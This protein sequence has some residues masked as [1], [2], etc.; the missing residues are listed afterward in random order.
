MA[1]MSYEGLRQ[2]GRRW[3]ELRRMQCDLGV[4]SGADGSC[5]FTCGRTKIIASCFVV[6]LSKQKASAARVPTTATAAAASTAP[7]VELRV[8]WLPFATQERRERGRTDRQV[9]DLEGMLKQTACAMLDAS[10][11]VVQKQTASGRGSSGAARGNNMEVQIKVAVLQADGGVRSCCVNAVTC[12]IGMANLVCGCLVVSCGC[13][14][15]QLGRTLRETRMLQSRGEEE[16]GK[17]LL[18]DPNGAETT[19]LGELSLSVTSAADR[20]QFQDVVSINCE[21]KLTPE[22]FE[23][24]VETCAEGCRAVS[25]FLRRKLLDYMTKVA[26]ISSH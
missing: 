26:T 6:P 21:A 15:Q 2:D 25:K 12:A 9:V 13:T 10:S 20:R 24:A 3:N 22:E 23:E 8:S 17:R 1:I 14:A 7:H 16:E 19:K 4:V 11:A 5:S 18:L